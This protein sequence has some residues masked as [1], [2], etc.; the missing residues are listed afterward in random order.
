MDIQRINPRE[1]NSSASI[2]GN[3]VF[4]SGT[5]ADD[6]SLDMKGQTE[7]VLQKIDAML[8]KAGTNKSRILSATVYMADANLK[9]EMNEA[10]MAWVDRANLPTRTAV[11]AALTP[12]TLVE[13]TVCAA[14]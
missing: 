8:A 5:V 6:K 12:G 10:W 4:L 11:G 7:Q 2:F 14:K 3:L 13:I 9:D 1:W